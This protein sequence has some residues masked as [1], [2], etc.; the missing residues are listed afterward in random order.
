MSLTSAKP[1]I[2]QQQVLAQRAERY[3]ILPTRS[4][5]WDSVISHR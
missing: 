3:V 4:Y 5:S 1:A 2:A